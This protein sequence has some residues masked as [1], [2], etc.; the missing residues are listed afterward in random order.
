[1]GKGYKGK[2]PRGAKSQTDEEAERAW[3][4]AERER[5]AER[6]QSRPN[7]GDMPSDDEEEEGGENAGGEEAKPKNITGIVHGAIG[8]LPPAD[9]EDEEEEEEEDE[10]DEPE[11]FKAAP[12]KK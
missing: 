9:D 11:Y 7:V 3:R 4:E 1:M 12:K 10:D 5:R 6:A 8:E 2:N